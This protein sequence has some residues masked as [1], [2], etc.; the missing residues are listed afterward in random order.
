MPEASINV[1]STSNKLSK[2]LGENTDKYTP[3]KERKTWVN[4]SPF[5][6][7]ELN[8]FKSYAL[9]CLLGKSCLSIKIE[10]MLM[11]QK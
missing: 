9:S 10:K 7:K 8:K 2:I 3:Q 6:T 11:Q 4:Q 1:K 5:L